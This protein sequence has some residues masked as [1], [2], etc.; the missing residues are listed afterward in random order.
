[1]PAHPTRWRPSGSAGRRPRSRGRRASIAVPPRGGLLPRQDADAGARDA[2]TRS[3]ARATRPRAWR[4]FVAEGSDAIPGYACPAPS[5]H[6]D[7]T[8]R[9]ASP[10]SR[11]SGA[12]RC[13]SIP[14][15]RRPRYAS[16]WRSRSPESSALPRA[17]WFQSR[18]GRVV[19]SRCLPSL[20][21]PTARDTHCVCSRARQVLNARTDDVLAEHGTR[22][23]PANGPDSIAAAHDACGCQGLAGVARCTPSLQRCM[24]ANS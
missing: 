4:V 13:S 16:P 15:C 23:S 20:K 11:T 18:P 24:F 22:H 6:A 3:V 5:R 2:P 1:M 10:R 12:M 9:R 17:P 14:S 8:I 7:R 21:M 19:S